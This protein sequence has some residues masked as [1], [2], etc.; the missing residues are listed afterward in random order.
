MVD[1]N[2]I[3]RS[4]IKTV[5]KAESISEE[6][7]EGIRRIF[8]AFKMQKNVYWGRYFVSIGMCVSL[9][10]RVIFYL[11]Y[12]KCLLYVFLN[13]QK[14]RCAHFQIVGKLIVL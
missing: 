6:K 8:K 3:L 4:L 11:A 5:I 10:P 1:A 2:T 14:L 9:S 12:F 13:E 7:F